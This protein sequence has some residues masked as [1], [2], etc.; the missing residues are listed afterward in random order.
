MDRL[1]EID[2]LS[3][4]YRVY[5]V[6]HGRDDV[7]GG[8]LGNRFAGNY[9]K[10]DNY[11]GLHSF[12]LSPRDGHLF[13]TPSMRRALL[14]FDPVSKQFTEWEMDGGFYP[15]T[16][17]IDQ[18]D[19]V[20]FTLALSSR[21][22]MFDRTSREFSYYDLPPRGLKERLILWL[23]EWRLGSGKTGEPPIRPRQQRL[24]NALWHRYR[25]R[26]NGV[27][28]ASLCQRYRAHRP[29]HRRGADDPHPLHGTA[30]TALRRP[31]KFLQSWAFPRA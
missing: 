30:Q 29:R 18:Q 14:E 21:V 12:A 22:A 6:P 27:G 20:W 31:G 23:A 19:R 4:E 24:P 9:P 13:V 11:F 10:V 25:A 2:P 26:W 17:R 15:H 8:I 5:K 7:L 16:V 1:Y 3:G 28:G